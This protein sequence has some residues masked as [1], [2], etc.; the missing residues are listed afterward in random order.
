MVSPAAA[1]GPC[2]TLT[3]APAYKHVI[4]IM[5]ENHS[6]NTII[7]SSQAPYINSLA[8]ETP[9]IDFGPCA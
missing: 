5:M 7:G 3:T 2:G 1:S 9:L 4:V 6:Y 8:T